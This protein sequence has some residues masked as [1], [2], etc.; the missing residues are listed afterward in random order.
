MG[1]R[2]KRAAAGLGPSGLS[3]LFHGGFRFQR[4]DREASALER[5]MEGLEAQVA[6]LTAKL[7][8]AEAPRKRLEK[9]NNVRIT[10]ASPLPH[11]YRCFVITVSAPHFSQLYGV[12]S[13]RECVTV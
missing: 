6:E 8:E 2:S 9:E 1:F 4:R 3:N 11:L 5:L 10:T 13:P 12:D 7:N